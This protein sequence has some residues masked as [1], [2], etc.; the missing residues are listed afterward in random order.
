MAFA[1]AVDFRARAAI[2]TSE[3]GN[4]QNAR[5]YYQIAITSCLLLFGVIKTNS[6]VLR[7]RVW[8][9]NNCVSR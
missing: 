5:A 2:E 4:R 8:R 6:R 9:L 7:T 3:R 1:G